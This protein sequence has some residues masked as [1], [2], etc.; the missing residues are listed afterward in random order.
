VSLSY[1][2][3]P[4]AAKSAEMSPELAPVGPIYDA[5]DYRSRFPDGRIGSNPSLASADAGRQL[6][7][8]AVE[9]VARDYGEFL[10]AP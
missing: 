3:Y 7:R 4:E 2:A 1:F 9:D 10:Q 5:D 6:Y 8:V